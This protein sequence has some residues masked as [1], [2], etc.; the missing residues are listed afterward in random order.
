MK[1]VNI[2]MIDLE[3]VIKLLKSYLP[4]ANIETIDRL[5]DDIIPVMHANIRKA[6]K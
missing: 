5:A 1:G 2:I 4:G 3:E 6:V